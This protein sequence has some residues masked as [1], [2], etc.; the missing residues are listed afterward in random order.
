MH[1][2]PVGYASSNANVAY[3]STGISV[4]VITVVVDHAGL[5]SC[6][7]SVPHSGC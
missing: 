2:M 4:I 3:T 1:P 7:A 5:G 6:M